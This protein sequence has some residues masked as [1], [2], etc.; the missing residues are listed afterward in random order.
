MQ[1]RFP[2]SSL[3]KPFFSLRAKTPP[4]L[5]LY[6]LLICCRPDRQNGR[7]TQFSRIRPMSISATN[8]CATSA[9]LS[10]R[11]WMPIA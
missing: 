1:D 10:A 4:G 11:S 8:Q 7:Q 3:P 5:N 6:R 9:T 2:S